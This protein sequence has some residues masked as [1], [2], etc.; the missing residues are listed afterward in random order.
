MKIE[1][2]EISSCNWLTTGTTQNLPT[3][4]ESI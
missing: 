4:L 3:R 1:E 2:R